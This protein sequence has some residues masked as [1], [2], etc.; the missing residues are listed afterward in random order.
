M[1]LQY[2]SERDHVYDFEELEDSP[3]SY[4][5]VKSYNA[6]NGTDTVTY[7][8]NSDTVVNQTL[9]TTATSL[10]VI[11]GQDAD[12]TTTEYTIDQLS[13]DTN[14]YAQKVNYYYKDSTTAKHYT[15]ESSVTL[16]IRYNFIASFLEL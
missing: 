11:F 10:Y 15:T 8:I 5:N 4:I 14:V 1:Y 13:S 16:T 9:Q 2:G 3:D 12:A 7:Y 6:Y